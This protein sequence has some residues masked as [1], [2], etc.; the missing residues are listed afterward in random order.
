MAALRI[1]TSVPILEMILSI[2]AV[3]L[4]HTT[5][6]SNSLY[7][8]FQLV[9]LEIFHSRIH[10]V[11]FTQIILFTCRGLLYMSWLQLMVRG[12]W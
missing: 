7:M 2:V 1:I 9:E 10:L 8:Y 5:Q 3:S 4:I 6:I 12:Y 11:Y